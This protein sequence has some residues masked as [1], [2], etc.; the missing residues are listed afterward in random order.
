MADAVR[1]IYRRRQEFGGLK[2]EQ[3]AEGASGNTAAMAIVR[4]L[5]FY[6]KMVELDL[7]PRQPSLLRK[8]RLVTGRDEDCVGR[9]R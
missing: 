2:I 1:Q 6:A 5:R 4:S 9:S 8:V 3:A 7:M